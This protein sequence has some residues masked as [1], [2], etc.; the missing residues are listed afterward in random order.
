MGELLGLESEVGSQAKQRWRDEAGCRKRSSMLW[1]RDGKGS[2]R[3]SWPGHNLWAGPDAQL[4][5]SAGN[6]FGECTGNGEH[7]GGEGRFGWAQGLGLK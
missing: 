3:R 5:W 1:C 2:V 6:K 4:S 7:G